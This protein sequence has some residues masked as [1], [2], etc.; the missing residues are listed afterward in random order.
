MRRVSERD[1]RLEILYDRIAWNAA[2]ESD[3]DV[4]IDSIA[5]LLAPEYARERV[6]TYSCGGE[7]H[8]IATFRHARAGIELQLVPG[9]RYHMGQDGWLVVERRMGAE[10]ELHAIRPAG[11]KGGDVEKPVHVVTVQPFLIGRFPLTQGEWDRIGGEDARRKRQVEP[12]GLGSTRDDPDLPIWDF[13]RAALKA[14]LAKAGGELRLP[15]EAEW[16]YACRAGT[17]TLYFWG[18]RMDR[19]Y[20]WHYPDNFP[21]PVRAHAEKPNAFG[22]VDMLGNVQEWCEDDWLETYAT[23]PRDQ[24]PRRSDGKQR[25]WVVRGG[26]A[27]SMPI[28]CRSAYRWGPA[29]RGPPPWDTVLGARV[30]RSAPIPERPWPEPEPRAEASGWVARVKRLLGG[31]T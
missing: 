28:A 14:W 27:S 2:A 11:H 24:R 5:A 6:A 30:A 26:G 8:R 25:A 19:S 9:G 18:D 20:C 16:E 31:S 3:Q 21:R 10:P 29:V 1:P 12:E 7:T 13:G 4:A 22:V 17:S 23:G 15:S